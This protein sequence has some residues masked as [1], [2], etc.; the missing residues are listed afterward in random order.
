M[1]NPN[2]DPSLL[3]QEQILQQAYN[4]TTQRLRVDAEV[5]AEIGDVIV[6]ESVLPTGAATSAA[7]TTAQTSLS[8]I[9][10]NTGSSATAAHQVTA[11]TSLSSIVTNTAAG[12]TAAAQTT[13]NTTLS[14][15]A[16]NTTSI[17]TAAH[18]V[19]AQT[20][21]TSIDLKST[22]FA[23]RSDSHAGVG[24]GT[25][26]NCSTT[27]FKNFTIQVTSTGATVWDI[28][29]EGSLDGTTFTTILTHTNVTPGDTLTISSGTAN[30]PMLYFRSRCAGMTGAGA[31]A[32]IIGTV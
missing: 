7:Q 4:E 21:L 18:Q 29:L 27:P 13:G 17:A 28:R 5:T 14:T 1:S 23:T 2:P 22:T 16:T 26:V 3:S 8:S 19:T 10:T 9:V 30:T 25:T 12:A 24:N 6:T 31:N 11:Q 20:S 32:V 15:I